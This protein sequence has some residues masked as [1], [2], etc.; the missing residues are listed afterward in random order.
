MEP[1]RL[2]IKKYTFEGFTKCP[3]NNQ[4]LKNHPKLHNLSK[5]PKMIRIWSIFTELKI[6][7]ANKKVIIMVM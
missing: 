2:R 3:E 6:N 1:I 5:L 4:N 7:G